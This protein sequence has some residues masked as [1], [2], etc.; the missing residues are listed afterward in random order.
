MSITREYRVRISR[1]IIRP[2]GLKRV[3]FVFG[4]K[5]ERCLIAREGQYI[6]YEILD[7][8]LYFYCVKDKMAKKDVDEASVYYAKRCIKYNFTAHQANFN[9]QEVLEELTP[10]LGEY[11]NA[12]PFTS[13][14]CPPFLRPLFKIDL[15]DRHPYNEI[16]KASSTREPLK[17]VK[18][19]ADVQK[20]ED[21]EVIDIMASDTVVEDD[22]ISSLLDLIGEQQEACA[23]EITRHEVEIAKLKERYDRL[24]HTYEYLRG[25]K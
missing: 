7:G 1:F 8:S 23:K 22:V 16:H 6:T 24:K 9:K 11:P 17:D 14:V 2:H 4:N 3:C 18:P 5:E 10:Y 15:K 20:I 19:A 21:K 25:G 13:T 12:Y